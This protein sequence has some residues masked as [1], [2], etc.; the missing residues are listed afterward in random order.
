MTQTDWWIEQVNKMK[1]L[2]QLKRL[3]EKHRRL[4]DTFSDADRNKIYL[5]IDEKKQTFKVKK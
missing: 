1:D 5:A 4:L 3:V 2:K